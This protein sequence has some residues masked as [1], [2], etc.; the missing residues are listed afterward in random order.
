MSYAQF[1]REAVTAACRAPIIYGDLRLQAAAVMAQYRAAVHAAV[2]DGKAI[3]NAELNRILK[4]GQAIL[5]AERGL[6][7]PWVFVEVAIIGR[8]PLKGVLAEI[9]KH[10]QAERW[11]P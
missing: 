10:L 3:D 9:L 2:A 11:A 8:L 1:K 6:L 5:T 7:E 4:D